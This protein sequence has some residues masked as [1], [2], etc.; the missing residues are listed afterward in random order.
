MSL[1]NELKRRNVVCVSVPCVVTA[2]L[3]VQVIKRFCRLS[4]SAMQ[5][6]VLSLQRLQ[7]RS[8]RRWWW[9]GCSSGQMYGKLD[10]VRF[11][12][13]PIAKNLHNDPRWESFLER[14]GMPSRVVDTLELSI[15]VSYWPAPILRAL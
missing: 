5:S 6:F 14:V 8:S 13:S 15:A 1:W 11:A 2:C 12:V 7:L 10:L 3:V 9:R 4:V